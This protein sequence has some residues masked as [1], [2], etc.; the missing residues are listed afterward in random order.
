MR[1]ATF[2]RW[3]MTASVVVLGGAGYIGSQMAK[4]LSQAGYLVTVFDNLSTGHRDAVRFGALVEGDL[5]NRNAMNQLFRDARFD[6]VMH[7]AALCYVGE[8]MRKPHE[9]YENNVVGTINV[10]DAMRAAG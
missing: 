10:L 8:S 3:A 9:Y 5:R 7:F 4:A 2:A 1:T 6:A